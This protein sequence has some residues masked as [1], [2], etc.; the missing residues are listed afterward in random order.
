MFI[1]GP[2]NEMGGN[3]LR[4]RAESITDGKEMNV[5]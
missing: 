1:N 2:A 5:L 4:Q 3:V